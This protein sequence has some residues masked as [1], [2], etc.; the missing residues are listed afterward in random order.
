MTAYER[1]IETLREHPACLV[2]DTPAGRVVEVDSKHLADVL[3]TVKAL[4]A[5]VTPLKV[6][7]NRF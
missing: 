7:R 5:S 3:F 6:G 2:R 4:K 1:I